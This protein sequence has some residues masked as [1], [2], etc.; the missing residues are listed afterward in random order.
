MPVPEE[1][2]RNFLLRRSSY[3]Y[4]LENQ[5]IQNMLI[6]YQQALPAMK[7]QLEV[8]QSEATTGFTKEWRIQRMKGQVAEVEFLLQVAGQQSSSELRSMLQDLAYLDSDVYARML[9]SQFSKI[10]IDIASLPYRQ[11]DQILNNP[12]R[13]IEIGDPAFWNKMNADVTNRIRGE[14]TQSIILGEDMGK[15]TNRII[16]LSK[17]KGFGTYSTTILAQR[18][19]M[20]ARSEIQYV[21]NQVARQTYT[22]NQDVL[23]GMQHSSTLDR[24][25]CPACASL[26]GKVYLFKDGDIEAPLLPLHPFCRCC[27]IPL[28]KSW[29]ELGVKVPENKKGEAKA[30]TGNPLKD[31]LT[32]GQWLKKQPVAV[33]KEILGP[34]RF[35]LWDSGQIELKQMTGRRGILRNVY[36]KKGERVPSLQSVSNWQLKELK[37]E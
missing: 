9:D 6:P 20:I 37:K 3:L 36:P 19:E 29:E 7:R 15:A 13:G 12:L 1:Q 24:R 21:S 27:Y 4:Q 28:T 10:G 23:K 26:D 30:F 5:A 17:Q 31:Q 18:A 33:Q 2:F 11:V 14:L 25:T 8:L 22:E 16:D 32:Y 35:E 34:A